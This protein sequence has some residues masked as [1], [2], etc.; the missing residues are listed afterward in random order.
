MNTS[1]FRASSIC[2]RPAGFVCLAMFSEPI[3]IERGAGCGW[4]G[5]ICDGMAWG[6]GLMVYGWWYVRGVL[7]CFCGIGWART[8]GFRGDGR[9]L[10]LWGSGVFRCFRLR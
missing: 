2:C 10:V 4:D 7:G 1:M 3:L 8:G 5:R 6:D 9:I